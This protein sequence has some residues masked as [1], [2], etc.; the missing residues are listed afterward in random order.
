MKWVYGIVAAIAIGIGMM[1]L[2][3]VGDTMWTSGSRSYT[4]G[5]GEVVWIPRGRDGYTT[6]IFLALLFL[7]FPIVGIFRSRRR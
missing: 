7:L 6:L 5:S 2:V 3:K 1:M 4:T